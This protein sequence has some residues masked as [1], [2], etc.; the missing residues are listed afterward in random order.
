MF[1]VWDCV[2]FP[3]LHVNHDIRNDLNGQIKLLPNHIFVSIVT[4]SLRSNMLPQSENQTDWRLTGTKLVQR[5]KLIRP[6]AG[7]R[8]RPRLQ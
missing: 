4:V 5:Q 6:Q 7:K 1:A 3:Y 2:E 8:S